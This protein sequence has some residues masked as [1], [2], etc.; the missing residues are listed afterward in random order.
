MI[1]VYQILQQRVD[2]DMDAS[3]FFILTRNDNTCGHQWKLQKPQ[4][5][6]RVQRNAFSVRV[7]KNGMHYHLLWLLPLASMPSKPGL[8]DTGHILSTQH[9]FMT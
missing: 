5:V 8:T 2:K 7:I 6:S 3:K 1:T 4:V 9:T